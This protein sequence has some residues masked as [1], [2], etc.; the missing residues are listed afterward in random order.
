MSV[1]VTGSGTNQFKDRCRFPLRFGTGT[2]VVGYGNMTFGQTI[3]MKGNGVAPTSFSSFFSVSGVPYKDNWSTYVMISPVLVMCG[4]HYYSGMTQQLRQWTVNEQGT[5]NGGA[6]ITT[7]DGF[8]PF[9]DRMFDTAVDSNGALH[10][11]YNDL[12]TNMGNTYL[13]LY[14]INNVGGTWNTRVEIYGASATAQ[15][16]ALRQPSII[17]DSNNLPIISAPAISTTNTWNRG[18]VN[19]ATSF[20]VQAL[21]PSATYGHNTLGCDIRGN[22]YVFARAGA[23]D[24]RIDKHKAGD[25]WGTDTNYTFSNKEFDQLYGVRIIGDYA[26]VVFKDQTNNP[27]GVSIAKIGISGTI[28]TY[29]TTLERTSDDW[30]EFEATFKNSPLYHNYDKNGVDVGVSANAKEIDL[31]MNLWDGAT[32]YD[33]YWESFQIAPTIALNTADASEFTDT[34]PTL[35][36]T[37]DEQFDLDTLEYDVQVMTDNLA[38]VDSYSESNYVSSWHTNGY[39]GAAQSFTGDGKYLTRATFYLFRSN[40]TPV[41][42]AKVKLYAH[43]GTFGTSSVPTGSPL[44]TSST[45]LAVST[46]TTT[47]TLV[48]FEF[49]GSFQ[50]VNGTKYVIAIEYYDG[51][52]NQSLQIGVDS[53]TPTH[54][55]NSSRRLDNQSY[56]A[57][58]T[59]DLIFYINGHTVLLDRASDID[60]SEFVNAASGTDAFDSQQS[61][62]TNTNINNVQTAL[63]QS[64][65]GQNLDLK[66]ASFRL[67]K[68]NSPTGNAVA[69]LYAHSGTYGTSSV[70]TGTALATSDTFDVSTLGTLLATAQLVEFNFSTPYTLSSG[71]NYV[72]VVEYT[73][74]TSTDYISARRTTSSVHSGNASHYISSW[75]ADSGFDLEFAVNTYDTHPFNDAEKIAFTVDGINIDLH[76][77]IQSLTFY[78][79]NSG[80]N[81]TAIGQSFTGSGDD[82]TGAKFYIAKLGSPT[83]NVF[84][85]LYAH[86]GTFGTSSVPTGTALATSNAFDIST[87]TTTNGWIDFT[88]GTPYTTV[89]GTKY[90]LVIEFTGGSAGNSLKVNITGSSGTLHNGNEC[91]YTGTWSADSNYDVLFY[92]YGTTQLSVATYYWRARARSGDL[93]G[94]WSAIRSFDITVVSSNVSKIKVGSWKDW[95]A[96]PQ[97][98]IG[99]TWKA[100]TAVKINIGGVWKDVDITP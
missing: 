29:V 56:V 31:P 59:V 83:G 39:D 38:V 53:T 2:P 79:L 28:P 87:L 64:F 100:I 46:L 96:N 12:T 7:L 98:N 92:A 48:N 67:Y 42:F 47:P 22:L 36:A 5:N 93:K 58:S 4:E 90:I 6:V 32:L 81:P 85:K 16:A 37:G 3:L 25:A 14:Y 68:T 54:S 89:N 66:S 45:A 82:L 91:L 97:I 34:T 21:S 26:Y 75:S 95:G 24:L 71:T 40:T 76:N 77:T 60:T 43:T 11:I 84:V 55:G 44:A 50:L 33:P 73:N 20:S 10:V 57:D 1:Q 80:G 74:G 94:Y 86:S 51:L 88:F 63:G 61:Y 17:I 35:E 99:G 15:F 8:V 65:Q 13:T 9:A 27:N 69:K 70:P 72:I 49:D 62:N 78:Y 30:Y 52:T 18:N 19:N 23:G 41:G